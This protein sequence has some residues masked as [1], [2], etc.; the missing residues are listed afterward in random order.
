MLETTLSLA[1]AFLPVLLFLA[2]LH[3]MDSYK[4]VRRS[5]IAAA[6][7][8]GGTAAGVS[9]MIN[10]AAFQCFPEQAGAFA[11]AGAPVVEEL[12]KGAYWMFLIS[13]ARVAFMV[14]AGICA[15]AGGAG[16]ALVENFF[17]L[18]ILGGH[19]LG[20][21]ILRG[22]GTATMHGGVAAIAAMLSIFLL[23]RSGQHGPR[24][25]APGLLVA[26]AIH[27]FFNQGLL[28]PVASTIVM[29][30]SIP[31]LLVV[32]FLWSEASLRHW[33][34][35]K[36][37]KD[38]E[39]MNMIATGELHRTRSGAYLQSLQD[40]FPPAIRADMLCM[41]QLTLELSVRA[42][43]ELMLREAGLEVP[44]DPEIEAQFREL[45]YLERSIGRTGMLA[46]GPLLSQTPRDLWEM[47][48][49]G[50]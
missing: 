7:L 26:M 41:L 4:L 45:A 40:A 5:R 1:A 14:D 8:A 29:L 44:P 15:F 23:E 22:F 3:M 17:Y 21:F 33:L 34:G 6:I 2:V 30:V 47:R 19:R 10:T 28:S 20:V 37:D 12:A 24:L 42:K 11:R 39:L 13:T 27:S 43:G 9:F 35:D 50:G 16:F 49:L 46:V 32:V 31:L 18:Q 25:F 36:M 38:I 48:S